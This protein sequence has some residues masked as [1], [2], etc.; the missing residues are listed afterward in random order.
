LQ[1]QSLP[2]VVDG[3]S[4]NEEEDQVL[5]D[6][7]RGVLEQKIKSAEMSL[8]MFSSLGMGIKEGF[9]DK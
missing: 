4:K 1:S 6:T 2:P 3:G 5:Y 9:F 7:S 8:M